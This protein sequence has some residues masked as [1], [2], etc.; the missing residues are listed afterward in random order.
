MNQVKSHHLSTIVE[1]ESLLYRDNSSPYVVQAEHLL[2]RRE[3]G[4]LI[5]WE[6]RKKATGIKSLW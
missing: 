5:I 4:A 2:C 6:R 1:V 3:K